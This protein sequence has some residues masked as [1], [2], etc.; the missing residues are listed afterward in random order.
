MLSM[1][2]YLPGF[3]STP[4]PP[5]S[6]TL[7]PPPPPPP[8]KPPTSADPSVQRAR[9]AA[10]REAALKAGLAGTNKTGGVLTDADASTAKKG[11][12]T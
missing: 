7:P 2:E 6:A 10:R 4:P 1:L 11:L 9:K 8:P 3:S 5:A 12:I